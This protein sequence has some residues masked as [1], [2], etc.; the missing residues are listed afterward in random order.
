MPHPIESEVG[1]LVPLAQ[2]IAR[3][4]VDQERDIIS[5]MDGFRKAYHGIGDDLLRNPISGE[6]F[7]GKYA[8]PRE[9]MPTFVR[10]IGGVDYSTARASTLLVR[11]DE[12]GPAGTAWAPH[13]PRSMAEDFNW[14]DAD[15]LYFLSEAIDRDIRVYEG[16]STL[17]ALYPN[18][19]FP[20]LKLKFDGI[21]ELRKAK[22]NLVEA[23]L[24]PMVISR[25]MSDA[26]L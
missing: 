10:A 2:E 18:T 19:E 17:Q 1:H 9:Y 4:F 5:V 3:P 16:Q 12:T 21:Q 24:K 15:W 20:V 13:S 25:V 23:I 8:K 7:F 11:R 26:G 6:W 14:T 22:A